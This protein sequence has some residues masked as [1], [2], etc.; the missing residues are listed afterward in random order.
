MKPAEKIEKYPKQIICPIRFI[1]IE[2]NRICRLLYPILI[3]THIYQVHM[4]WQGISGYDVIMARM[5]FVKSFFTDRSSIADRQKVETQQEQVAIALQA[6]SEN[7][8]RQRYRFPQI[9]SFLPRLRTLNSLCS[10]AFSQIQV[11]LIALIF[12]FYF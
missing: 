3:L 11:I 9:M 10:N 4:Y 2:S 5:T 7:M 8:F 12:C 1:E 6:Y